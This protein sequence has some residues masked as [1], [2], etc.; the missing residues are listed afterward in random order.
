MLNWQG[1]DSTKLLHLVNDCKFDWSEVSDMTPMSEYE[2][3]TI[4]AGL[5]RSIRS[6]FDLKSSAS[7]YVNELEATWAHA[8]MLDNSEQWHLKAVERWK[9]LYEDE[10]DPGWRAA[11]GSPRRGPPE[12]KQQYDVLLFAAVTAGPDALAELKRKVASLRTERLT[13]RLWFFGVI[14]FPFAILAF[15]RGWGEIFRSG[16]ASIF[17]CGAIT[18]TLAE[19]LSEQAKERFRRFREFS[20]YRRHHPRIEQDRVGNL[21]FYRRLDFR[22]F[23]SYPAILAW[24][25]YF[26]VTQ[27]N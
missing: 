18:A 2:A 22:A 3:A 14:G 13:Q 24:N 6:F 9:A 16:D 10:D 5:W 26:V 17:I 11:R 7:A 23:Y 20:G 27:K 1:A 19:N 4:D 25:M 8:G 21:Y 12:D 15:S